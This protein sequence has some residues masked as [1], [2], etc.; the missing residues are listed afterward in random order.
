M[1]PVVSV[2]GLVP[3]E[4]VAPVVMATAPT[5]PEPASVAPLETESVP[6]RLP[7]ALSVPAETVVVPA[8]PLLFPER[9]VSPLPA[10]TTAPAPEI[11]PE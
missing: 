1:L 8:K 10:C 6:P 9:V 7:L 5:V 3:G 11:V 4:S 2:P